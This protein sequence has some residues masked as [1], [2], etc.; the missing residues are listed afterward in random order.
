MVDGGTG[1]ALVGLL[2]RVVEYQRLPACGRGRGEVVGCQERLR[3]C[4]GWLLLSSIL[5][6]AAVVVDDWLVLMLLQLLLSM[7]RLML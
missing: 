3:H 6:V 5:T 2:L 7:L 4:W 1:I